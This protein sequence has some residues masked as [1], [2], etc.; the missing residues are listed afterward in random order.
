MKQKQTNKLYYSGDDPWPYLLCKGSCNSVSSGKLADDKQAIKSC[1]LA[2]RIRNWF[3][4]INFLVI[5]FFDTFLL[6]L[7]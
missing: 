5:I 7:R 3:L 2:F 1:E 4:L 6:T